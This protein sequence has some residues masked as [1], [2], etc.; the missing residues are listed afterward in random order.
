V[1]A[2]SDARLALWLAPVATPHAEPRFH[3]T[4]ETVRS[5]TA[6]LDSPAAGPP[7][8]AAV[9]SAGDVFLREVG[10]DLVVATSLAIALGH[11]EGTRGLATGLDLVGALARAKETAPARPR[12]RANAL[13]FLVARGESLLDGRPPERDRAALDALSRSIEA[14]LAS[15]SDALGADAPSFRPL[16]D[17]VQRARASLPSEVA[18]APAPPPPEPRAVF[19]PPPPPPT[20]PPLSSSETVATRPDSIP[21]QLRKS[22]AALLETA[23]LMRAASPLDADA[24]RV[25]LV[26]LYLPMSAS[27]PTTRGA[28]T[29]LPPPPKLALDSI[30][31]SATDA[32]PDALV[33]DILSAL[34]RNRLALDLHLHLARALDRAGERGAAAK[35]VHAHELRGLVTRLPSLSS[36]EFSD[37]SPFATPPTRE[38]FDELAR[39]PAPALADAASPPLRETA[40]ELARDGRLPDAL[41]LASRA[42]NEAP[43]GRARF[44]ATLVLASIAE[45][46]RALPLAEE[47]H[48]SLLRELEERRI[49]AWDPDLAA[50]ALV[51]HLRFVRGAPGKEAL[52]KALFGRLAVVDPTLA[53]T[54]ATT[55]HAT[56]AKTVR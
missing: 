19:E 16:V 25:L 35:S 55:A 32:A 20:P 52:A 44:E 47:L 10:K 14:A 38:M 23:L 37:G 8:W 5:E 30:E 40:R 53:L 18:P 33:R 50:S 46:A 7:D 24:L 27:P 43:S 41:A 9:L 11:R 28:R 13:A 31:R 17:R 4:Y 34:E 49:D 36:L 42:R 45:E 3:P 48:A 2:V 26:A 39:G 56:P 22:A 21:T 54:F 51:A 29:S 12:A 6:K 15:A 1:R